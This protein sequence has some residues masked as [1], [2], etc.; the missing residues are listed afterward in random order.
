MNR[1]ALVQWL[2]ARLGMQLVPSVDHLALYPAKV[3]AQNG[4]TVDVQCD[5][6]RVGDLS[7][8]PLQLGIPDCEVTV[9][10]GA[11][12]LVGWH[13]GDARKP[14]V[15]LWESGA[16]ATEIKIHSGTK[17]AA[18]TDDTLTASSAL[19]TWAQ[20]VEAGIPTGTPPATTFA[21]AAG[22]PGGLGDI[23]GGSTTVK[24]G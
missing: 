14:F 2:M 20:A 9:S 21:L 18:R 10:A 19:A 6:R 1:R 24:I 8:V 13:G 16:T 23:H 7:S 17:G 12:V 15:L 4:Q 22:L 5:D 11:R 3:V